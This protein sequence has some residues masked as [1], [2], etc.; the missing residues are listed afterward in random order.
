M[1]SFDQSKTGQTRNYGDVFPF[2]IALQDLERQD[3]KLLAHSPV[4]IDL[5]YAPDATYIL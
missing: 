3:L 5:P 4:F 1:K 2:L